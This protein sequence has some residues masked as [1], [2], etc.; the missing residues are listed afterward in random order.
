YGIGPQT[1]ISALRINPALGKELLRQ[2][3][4]G[5][6]WMHFHH[7]GIEDQALP[8]IEVPAGQL[9]GRIGREELLELLDSFRPK[10]CEPIQYGK[11]LKSVTKVSGELKLEFANGAEERANAVWGCD[12]MNSLCWHVLIFPIGG[13]KFVNIAAFAEEAVHKKRGRT[14]KTSTEE[15]LTYFPGSNA[16]VQRLLRMLND[17]P[18]GCICLELMATEKLGKFY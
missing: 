8:T 16:T 12:G 4:T 11:T 13:G 18:D 1:L 9:Y 14:Y 5:P 17:Q 3:I 2:C 10:D 6:V 7:G 15:L